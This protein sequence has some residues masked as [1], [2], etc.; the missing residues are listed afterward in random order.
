[1]P[2]VDPDNEELYEKRVEASRREDLVDLYDLTEWEPRT[3]FDR[4]CLGFSFASKYLIVAGFAVAVL[5]V[6]GVT[7]ASLLFSPIAGVFMLVSV[8]PAFFIVWYLWETDPSDRVPLRL[9]TVTFLLSCL[10][11]TIPFTVNTATQ[12]YFSMVPGGM[13]IFFYLV[14]A[15]VEETVKWGAVRLYAY[16][17]D[18]FNSPAD[19]AVLGAIAGLAFATVENGIYLTGGSFL[20]LGGATAEMTIGRAGVAPLH[21]LWS[22]IA[23]YYLALAKLNRKHAT[24]IIFKGLLIAGLLHGTYNV[25]VTYLPAVAAAV[26][27]TVGVSA[28]NVER[29]LL[30]VFLLSFYAAVAYYPVRKMNRYRKYR[31]RQRDIDDVRDEMGMSDDEIDEFLTSHGTGVLSLSQD[32]DSYSM[33]ISYGYDS[34]EGFLCMMLAFAPMSKKRNWVRNTEKANFVVHEIGESLEAKSVFVEGE[35]RE[36]NEDEVEA[37]YDSLSN[38][39]LFTVLHIS[40][41]KPDDTD[42]KMYRLEIDSVT[43][44]KFEHRLDK[45]LEL[46]T[47]E[48]RRKR[49]VNLSTRAD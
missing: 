45:A 27:P 23:G 13:V 6:F 4:F 34:D 47:V 42:F 43:G 41:A 15:P 25:S 7:A 35:L 49:L 1:M 48:K 11:V 5:L 39:A 10:L 12:W 30:A 17:D 2:E 28:D 24:T 33:P 38:N 44:R 21:V 16:T 37:G 26:E 14:V 22:A 36:L 19:G 40:G 32:N 9:I 29:T 18:I 8:V 20:G 46:D 31:L 3:A